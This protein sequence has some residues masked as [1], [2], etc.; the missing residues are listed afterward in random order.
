MILHGYFTYGN[1]MF[2]LSSC[3]RV[4]LRHIVHCTSVCVAEGDNSTYDSEAQAVKVFRT[5]VYL[6][7]NSRRRVHSASR[8]LRGLRQSTGMFSPLLILGQH[9][10][11]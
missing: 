6:V 1:L 2:F 10:E 4:Y 3:V 5:L 11:H 7:S 9:T 8:L